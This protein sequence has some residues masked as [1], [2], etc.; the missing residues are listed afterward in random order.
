MEDF[1]QNSVTLR[2]I[3]VY[4][5]LRESNLVKSGN[6]F[7]LS[8]ETSPSQLNEIMHGRRNVTVEIIKN[9][10]KKF[11][12]NPFYLFDDSVN[13][14]LYTQNANTESSNPKQ[15]YEILLENNTLKNKIIE[16]QDFIIKNSIKQQ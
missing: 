13:D 1:L 14:I 12:V 11:N 4:R 7:A 16:L 6:K 8:L 15:P 3:Q 9:L 2:F 5:F 10:I